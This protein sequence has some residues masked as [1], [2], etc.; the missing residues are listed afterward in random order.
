[1]HRNWRV[2]PNVCII[3]DKFVDL[4]VIFLQFKKSVLVTGVGKL[5]LNILLPAPGAFTT[6]NISRTLIDTRKISNCSQF[7]YFVADIKQF[8][9]LKYIFDCLS[10]FFWAPLAFSISKIYFW[11]SSDS[12]PKM[13]L[14]MLKYNFVQI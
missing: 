11:Y 6:K 8:I 13:Y 4:C 7:N 2:F 10:S 5:I 9:I 3:Q 12:S 1:M 14:L